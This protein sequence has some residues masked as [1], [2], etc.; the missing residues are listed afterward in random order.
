MASDP[1]SCAAEPDSPRHLIDLSD[2]CL[3]AIGLRLADPL[4]PTV[5]VALK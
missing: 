4:R 2:D 1:P 5:A 3:A